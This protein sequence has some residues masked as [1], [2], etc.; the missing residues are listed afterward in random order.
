[1]KHS[2]VEFKKQSTKANKKTSQCL[3]RVYKS[4]DVYDRISTLASENRIG[5][6]RIQKGSNLN[7]NHLTNLETTLI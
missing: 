5:A 6:K 4:L 2:R 1:M 3:G 7:T